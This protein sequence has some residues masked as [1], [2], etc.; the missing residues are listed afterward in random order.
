MTFLDPKRSRGRAA[1]RI[2]SGKTLG[3]ICVA[4]GGAVIATMIFISL[5]AL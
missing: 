2:V 5:S 3:A 1:E 4:A